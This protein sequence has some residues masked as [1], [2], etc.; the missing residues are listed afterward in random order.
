MNQE[1]VY[2]IFLPPPAD[3]IGTMEDDN[4]PLPGEATIEIQANEQW[5][6]TGCYRS[7]VLYA[8]RLCKQKNQT[9]E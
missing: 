7:H 1:I 2:N 6:I 3:G 5:T 8:V 9:K 4:N